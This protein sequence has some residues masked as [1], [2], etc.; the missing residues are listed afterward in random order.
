M[1]HFLFDFLNQNIYLFI[2]P[3]SNIV[4]LNCFEY[5]QVSSEPVSSSAA[6]RLNK[7]EKNRLKT[8]RRKERRRQRWLQVLE[9]KVRKHSVKNL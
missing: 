9:D 6:I 3:P 8:Q 7:K 1:S 2:N 5:I 4:Y